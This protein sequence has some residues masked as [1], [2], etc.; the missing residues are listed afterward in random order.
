MKKVIYTILILSLLGGCSTKK[1]G[2]THRTY[3]RI[4]SWNNTLFNGQ[5]ALN[6]ELKSRNLRYRDN[7]SAILQ[8]EP[9][10]PWVDKK[11]SSIDFT[12]SDSENNTSNLS[13]ELKDNFKNLDAQGAIN[14]LSDALG[15]MLGAGKDS[16]TQGYDKAIEKGKKA[17]E[18]HS[19]LIKGKEYN[20]MMS[21]AY[22]L[23]AR[24]YYYKRDPFESLNYLN[25]MNSTLFK[26]TK[27]AQAEGY[28]ALALAQAGNSF[29]ANEIYEKLVKQKLKKRDE[30]FISKIYSQ[31]LIDEKRYQDAVKALNVAKKYN[32]SAN[33]QARFNF[34]QGQLSE[35]LKEEDQARDYYNSAYKKKSVPE[36][37]IKSQIALSRLYKKEDSLTYLGRIKFLKGLTKK[38]L[39]QSRK[40]EIYYAMGLTSLREEREKDAM[41]YFF[42]SLKERESDPQTRAL[43]YQE[44]GD[45]YFSK[46]NYVYASAYYDSAISRFVDPVMKRKLAVKNKVLDNITQKYYLVKKNDSILMI[47]KMTPNQR[48]TYYQKY[49]NQIKEKEEQKR[50]QQ[51]K[52]QGKENTTEFAT[53]TFENNM[54][55]LNMT[56]PNTKGK[57]YFYNNNLKQVG[58]SEFRKQWG[59]RMLADNWRMSNKI[60][61]L[62]DVKMQLS[63]QSDSKNPRRFEIEYYTENLPKTQSEI[64]VLKKQRDSVELSLGILYFDKLHD[65]KSATST[66]EHLLSTKPYNEEITVL[67]M[68]NLYRFNKEENNNLSKKYSDIIITQYPNTK[69]AYTILNPQT[70][71]LN[72]N[73]SE[74]I[75]F[76]E[77]TYKKYEKGNYK[78]AKELASQALLKYP[79]H[80]IIAK[81]I[82][83]SAFCDAKLGNKKEF[84]QSLENIVKVYK[85]KEEGK[86]ATELLKT[87]NNMNNNE[88][89]L[90]ANDREIKK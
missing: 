23:L 68:Y 46:Q 56:T 29:Q 33:D 41:N 53:E 77:N 69:Y 26:N 85:D 17:I 25:Y 84:K 7:F 67:A 64:D 49:I 35:I 30:K 63:G 10:N 80:E 90:K 40:N 22:L 60:S 74:A 45:H 89:L 19:M 81:F 87:F 86:K 54:F 78:E 75:L 15:N 44:I 21:E 2:I 71:V 43:V 79:N 18:K 57:W 76:Y 36:L 47:A 66:L 4:T 83:L 11:E 59:D 65:I 48:N 72:T 12:L 52:I 39:Y 8:V 73:S 16:K 82:L 34:I 24:A 28:K 50:L 42:A 14:S 6:D 1:N 13:G 5:E 62:E 70:N 27:R 32:K 55:S 20:S 37:E 58:Q 3:H 51:E 38:G 31:F 88:K 61:N 9:G